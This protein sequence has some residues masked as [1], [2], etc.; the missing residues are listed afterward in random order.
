MVVPEFL[1]STHLTGTIVRTFCHRLGSTTTERKPGLMEIPN[2]QNKL[3]A[4]AK[5]LT[6]PTNKL[7]DKSSVYSKSLK[8]ADAIIETSVCIWFF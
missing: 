8:V 5:R 2:H 7:F 1:V 6:Y 4:R 3:P